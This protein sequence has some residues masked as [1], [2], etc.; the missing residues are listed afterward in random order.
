MEPKNKNRGQEAEPDDIIKA[1]FGAVGVPYPDDLGDWAQG[2]IRA[3][4]GDRA[5]AARTIT[6]QCAVEYTD[7]EIKSAV[8]D[9]YMLYTVTEIHR[10]DERA[11]AEV[12][13]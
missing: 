5:Q 2:E 9:A 11:P 7:D 10:K 12:L 4:R 13:E 1:V 8:R 3:A 6:E